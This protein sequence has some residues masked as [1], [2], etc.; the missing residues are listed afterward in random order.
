MTITVAEKTTGASQRDILG[1]CKKHDVSF[2]RLQFTDILGINKNVEVPESQ[3]EKAVAGDIMFDGS[4]I[5]GFVR[6]EESDMMLKP[7]LATFRILPYDDES[8][9]V[10]R[11]I[12]DIFNPDG[13][14][15]EGCTRQALKRQMARARALGYQMMA[16]CE[17]EFFIFQLDT[18][19]NPT[20]L[21]H[22]S[23]G[24]FDL[25]PVDRAEEIRRLIVKELVAM[26]LEVEAG[27]HEVAPGQ[28]EIDFRYADA[29]ETADNLATFRFIVRDVAYRNGFLATFMPKPIFGQNGSGMH[30]HQSLFQDGQNAFHDPDAPFELSNVALHYIAGL[31]AHARGFCAVTNPLVNSYK[32]LVPGFEA[33]TNIAWSMRN[34]SPLIRIPDRRGQGARCELRMP[35]PSANPYLALAVQLASGLDGLEQRLTPPDPVNKNIFEM[36]FRERRKYRIDELPRDLHEALDYLERDAVVREALGPHIYERFV[37]AKREEWQEYIARVSEWELERYLGRY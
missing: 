11:L 25:T 16:G 5:E 32:R 23:G 33:P 15:F 30:T 3:F 2:L 27:H 12:C 20:T 24:Y 9:R 22:D 10:A 17:A 26:G 21:T 8:G 1:L 37:E 6:I 35:D 19:R 18:E 14:A 7:D 36:S 4:S 28:H 29:L 34:R 31:L 13:S